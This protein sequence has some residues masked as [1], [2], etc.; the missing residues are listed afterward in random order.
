MKASARLGAAWRNDSLEVLW[1]DTERAFCKLWRDDADGHRHAFIPILSG[2]EHP[3]LE[4]VDRL[5]HEYELRDYLDGAWALRPLEFIRERGRA[6]LVVEY[7]AG[8]PLDRLIRGPMAIV[9]FLR[10]AVPLTAALGRLHGRGLLHKDIRP[11]NVIVDSAAGNVWLTGFS[12][13]C[14][15]PRETQSPEPPESIV[16][17]LAYMAPEQT[18]RMNRSI[19]ARSDLYSLGVTL[20]EMATGVLPFAAADPMEL[21]HSHIARQTMPPVERTPGVP[22]AISAVIMK[23]LAKTPEDRYQTAAGVDADLRRCLRPQ[24]LAVGIEPFALAVHD[25]P[26]VLRIPETLYG[27]EQSIQALRAAFERVAAEGSAELMLVSG[28]AGVGKSSVVIELQKDLDVSKGIFAAGKCDQ[29][30]RDIPYA[31][32]AQALRSLVQMILRSSE[33]ELARWRDSI[34][35]AVEP[36]GQLIASL[37][38]EFELVIGL[39]PPVPDL[40]PQDSRNRFQMVFR[41][42]LQVFARSGHPLVL[43]VD[44]LQWIDAATLALVEDLVG[45]RETRHLLLIGAYR[46]NEVGPSHPLLVA[47]DTLRHTGTPVNEIVLGALELDD[48]GRFVASALHCDEQRVRPLAHLVAE[49]TGG[50]PF[51]AI[52][53]LTE[54][55]AEAFLSFDAGV[56]TWTWNV[57]RIAAKGYTDNIVQLMVVKLKRLPA[58]AQEGLNEL[59]CLG[60]VA[61]FATLVIV[62]ESSDEEIHSAF[63]DATK[64][65]LLIRLESAYRFAHDRVQEAAYALIPQASRR[66]VHLRIGRRLRAA[67]APEP[68]AERL[69]VVVNQLNHAVDLIAEVGERMALLRLNVLAGVK[70][71]AGIAYCAAR[72]YL[73]QAAAL[74][75][76]DAW[77]RHYDETLELCLGLAE[78]EYLVGNFDAADQLFELMLGN[79]HSDPDRARIYSLRM[80]V[81]EVGGGYDESLILALKALKL[82]GVT[83]PESEDEIQTAADAEFRA[84]SV[85]L[86]GRRIGDLIDAPA[87]DAPEVR[88]IIDLLVDAVPS[89]YNGRP[90]L[91]PLMAMKAVNFSLLYGN[92]DQSGYAYAVHALMLAGVYGDMAQ[93]FEFSEMALRLNDKFNNARLRGTL[94]HLHGDHVNFW[95]RHFATGV[96]ILE[97]GLRACLEV[98][99]LVYAGHLAF[100]MVWQANERGDR[101]EEVLAL[102][103]RNGSVASQSHNDAVYETIQLEQQFV[104]SLLGRTSDPLKF[105]AGGFDERASLA[106]IAKA[107][108]GCGMV[109]HPIMKQI[110]AFLYGRHAEALD[111]ARLAEPMLGAAMATPIEATHHFYYALILTALYPSAPAAEQT[112]FSSL[113]EGKLKKLKLWADNCPQNYHNRYALVLAEIARIEG[114]PAEAMDLYEDAIRSARDNGFVQQ[115]ALAFEL[116]AR[117]YATRGFA[118][119]ARAYLKNARDGYLR[120]GAHGKVRQLDETYRQLREEAIAPRA[121]IAIPETVEHLDLATVVKVSEAVSGEIVLEKLIDTLMRTAIEHAGAERGLL[122][123]PRGDEHRIE[124]EVTTRGNEVI[125]DLRQAS[126]TAADLPESVFRYA[127][128]TRESVLLPDASGQNPFSADDYI[129]ERRARSVLCLPILKQTRLLGM[130]YLENN[131]T[132]HAFTPARMAILRL[133]AS[134]AASSMENARLYRDL[135]EREGRIRRLVDANI[136][137]IILCDVAG[138]ILEANDAFLR[139]V[140]YNREDFVSQRVRWTDMTPPEWRE[141]DQQQLVPELMRKGRLQPFEKEFFRKDGSRVPVLIGVANFEDGYQSVAFVLDLTERKH[142]ADALRALQMDLAHANRLA[143]MGQLAASIA[144]EV[145]QP[146]GAARNNAHAALRF[147]TGDPP[148]LEEVREAIECVVNDT[149]RAGDIISGIRDQVKKT[150]PRKAAVDLNEAIE[151]VIALVRGELSKHRVSIQ[152]RLRE[153]LSTVHA[154]R[155]QLQQVMLNLV[156]NAI[157]AIISVDDEGRELVISTESIPAEG[158]LVSFSDSGCGVAPEDRER[159]FESFYT[160]KAGGVGIGLSIC[161]SIIDAHSGRLWVDAHQPRGAVFRFT[162][163]LHN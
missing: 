63:R 121:P 105:D 85:N 42:F 129:R 75:A 110:L 84:V 92:T 76:A 66:E 48:L 7:T 46:D 68:T 56:A 163:P 14:R 143:T 141:R 72:D 25:I 24:Q 10:V 102:A 35:R 2:A 124:A 53:F 23:L 65:G 144:H 29:F 13:A 126:V 120:W 156:L 57:E 153:E 70:A 9:L 157:E 155:V 117:F 133:L 111:A 40:P 26:D 123:L 90:K 11:A 5:A 34:R 18:G 128:R 32:L 158:V 17:T 59:A 79:A 101:L 6:M 71:K 19:D 88:A 87:A 74:A 103:A 151:E 4:R 8:V 61:D 15:V 99:D 138:H 45:Q 52:Q 154:D 77:T 73:A 94:L 82:F 125:V 122:I 20:Y 21:V 130:L 43:F 146:I 51:F 150:P 159:I 100:L 16:G 49:K 69:F 96:P 106:T 107:A 127:L 67:S 44:D 97:Q 134:E 162:L 36:N 139:M 115:E 39:Q 55:A 98:G 161:R 132:P 50:N 22:A 80:K 62:R 109:F 47:L 160:T 33:A 131:L 119:F 149:Y 113:L 89:A 145:N 148:D 147:L 54:L 64:A 31:A 58:A 93:A 27:R 30:K 104:A 81:C 91:F 116:A 12:V 41:D 112:Q 114:R 140:G 142:A 78:C 37:I 137:G 28:Y 83:F 3:S 95:R 152:M 86:L 38:P 135:A 60:S 118:M 1:E 108:F 136:I